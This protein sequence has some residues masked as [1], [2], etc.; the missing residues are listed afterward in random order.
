MNSRA[1]IDGVKA[2]GRILPVLFS[3][4][5]C[6]LFL[7]AVAPQVRTAVD[8]GNVENG[9]ALERWSVGQVQGY[10]VALEIKESS[11]LGK[12]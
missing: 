2:I 9:D 6:P 4:G 12:N 11:L 3:L 1:E 7:C 8:A 10:A 5:L